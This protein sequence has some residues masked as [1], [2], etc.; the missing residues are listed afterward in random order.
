MLVLADLLVPD[1]LVVVR[2]WCDPLMGAVAVVELL[3]TASQ[4]AHRSQPRKRLCS[5]P[6]GTQ[7]RSSEARTNCAAR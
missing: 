4:D 2:V 6:A 3:V 1:L 7:V 5:A